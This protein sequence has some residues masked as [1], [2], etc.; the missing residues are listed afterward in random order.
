MPLEVV[1]LLAAFFVCQSTLANL[2]L[3]DLPTDEIDTVLDDTDGGGIEHAHHRCRLL[4]FDVGIG[5]V[6]VEIVIDEVETA[7][8]FATLDGELEYLVRPDFV[9]DGIVLFVLLDAILGKNVLDDIIEI[10]FELGGECGVLIL[11]GKIGAAEGYRVGIVCRGDTLR[12]GNLC[13]D[14]IRDGQ[15]R[16]RCVGCIALRKL[17]L[18][19]ACRKGC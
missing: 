6:S 12:G 19:C 4:D 11:Q 3:L 14:V 8:D 17:G 18:R 5:G 9:A 15:G 13:H 7:G 16:L 2:V 10:P 1:A